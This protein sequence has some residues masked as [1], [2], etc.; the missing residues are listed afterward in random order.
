MTISFKHLISSSLAVASV[1]MLASCDDV[2]EHNR[3]IEMGEITAERNVLLEDFTGQFCLNCPDAHEVIEQLEE[4]YGADKVIAVSI[5]SGSFGLDKK[6][7][8]FPANRVG[9]MTEE[10]NAILSGYGI[11]SF[12]MGVIDMGK[13][14]TYDLWPTAVYNEIRKPSDVKIDLKA[15]YHA[16]T[17][18]SENG[19]YGDIMVEADILS[20][21]DRTA[22]VQFWI[23]E[24]GI[25]AQ[26]K[27]GAQTINDYVHNNVFRAQVFDGVRG[28]SHVFVKGIAKQVKGSIPTRWT[29]QEHWQPTNL[30]VVAFVSDGSGVLQAVKVKLVK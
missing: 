6:Y 29:D 3:Y 25:V 23:I 14:M 17:A 15:E 13:P 30:A 20:G 1:M 27:K 21:S 18:D 26:Q 4:Q 12:P 7:T 8:S 16:D 9:L 19:Y 5:H 11:T 24:S 28:E 10:G 22:D 2:N